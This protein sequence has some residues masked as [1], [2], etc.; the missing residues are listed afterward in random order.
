MN[1]STVI[2]DNI[3]IFITLI[4]SIL[5]SI[6]SVIATFLRTKSSSLVKRM[7]KNSLIR[8][9]NDLDLYDI[10]INGQI[11]HLSDYTITKR[12]E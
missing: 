11:Y 1:W 9:S 5:T 4:L 3:E 2:A 7:S 12:K 10:D 6:G 8:V